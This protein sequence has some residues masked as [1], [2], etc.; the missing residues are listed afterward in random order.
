MLNASEKTFSVLFFIL[1][2]AELICGSLA[3]L[4][5]LHYFSKPAIVLSLLIFFWIQSKTIKPVLRYLVALALIC[6]LAGDILLMFVNHSPHYFMLGLVAFLI[7]HIMYIFAF[8][9]HRNKAVNPLTFIII[10]LL[11]ALGLFYLLKDGLKDMLLP[12]IVYM[13]AIL[14]MSTTALLR[15]GAVP[16]WSYLLVFFGALL[17]MISDSILAL[18]KFY[19]PLAYSDISIMLTYA[20]AQY[21]IV[22]GILKLAETSR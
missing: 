12:V 14:S 16:K 7:A 1:V 8:L 21:G 18:N 9:K 20:L 11:Y 5:H 2:I 3:A 22:L 17:F 13:I 15:K 19:A 10:L 4:E 6:S